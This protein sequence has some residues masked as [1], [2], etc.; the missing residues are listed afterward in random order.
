MAE[1]DK[2]KNMLMLRSL[3]FN[4]LQVKSLNCADWKSLKAKVESQ[5]HLGLYTEEGKKKIVIAS[6][7]VSCFEGVL[8]QRQKNPTF[9]SD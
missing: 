3:V 2:Y 4:S 5:S 9:T 1:Q 6:G 7:D 8:D